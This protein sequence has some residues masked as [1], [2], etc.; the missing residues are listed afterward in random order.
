MEV[1]AAVSSFIAIGQARGA[2]PKIVD[3]F[4]SFADIKGEFA[5]LMSEVWMDVMLPKDVLPISSPRRRETALA[6]GRFHSK[7]LDMSM[8]ADVVNS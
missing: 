7:L 8:T 6:A 3:T 4:R 5:L 2:L 1:I